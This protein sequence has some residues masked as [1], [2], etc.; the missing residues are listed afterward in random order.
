MS[1]RIILTI[2]NKRMGKNKDIMNG[3]DVSGMV[4]LLT[5]KTKLINVNLVP[6]I[7]SLFSS[8]D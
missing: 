2:Q 1:E 6:T 7:L 5:N 8:I 3:F 4:K